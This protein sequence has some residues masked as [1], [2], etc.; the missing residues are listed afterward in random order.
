MNRATQNIETL[1]PFAKEVFFG[2]SPGA[3]SQAA[4]RG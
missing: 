2:K 3:G 4:R 1:P